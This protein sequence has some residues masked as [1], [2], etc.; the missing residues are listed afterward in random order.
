[1]YGCLGDR[2]RHQGPYT[3]TLMPGIQSPTTGTAIEQHA[4]GMQDRSF[5]LEAEIPARCLGV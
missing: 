1:M 3:R 5:D 4:W 2:W